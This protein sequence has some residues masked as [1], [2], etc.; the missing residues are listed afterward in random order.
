[1][2]CVLKKWRACCERHIASLGFIGVGQF[3]D[4]LDNYLLLKDISIELNID[5]HSRISQMLTDYF[6][7]LFWQYFKLQF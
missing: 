4:K 1:V 6:P 2:N 5:V 3:V 7:L